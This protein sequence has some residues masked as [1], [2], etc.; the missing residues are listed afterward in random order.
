MPASAFA[1]LDGVV[2]DVDHRELREI[3]PDHLRDAEV[4]DRAV[5]L[6]TGWDAY[7]ESPA[8]ADHHSFLSA[9]G[10]AYLRDCGVAL[11]GIDAMNIDDTRGDARPAH[12]ILMGAQIP[13]VEH[14]CNLGA[15]PRDGFRFNALPPRFAGVGTFP[16][17]AIATLD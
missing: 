6:R 9:D 7:W 15:L 5:L 10:A 12:T 17:R 2:I 14:L 1:E 8:Y 4:R 16:V 13:I 3:G 11:V